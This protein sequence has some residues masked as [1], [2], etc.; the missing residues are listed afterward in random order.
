VPA[1]SASDAAPSPGTPARAEAHREI[2]RVSLELEGA[3]FLGPS[4]APVTLAM[5]L[6]YQCAF[7][8]RSHVTV[9]QLRERYGDRL[10]V[11]FLQNP[12]DNH[13]QAPLAARALLAA[14]A[15]GRLEEMHERLMV[16]SSLEPGAILEQARAAGLDPAAFAAGLDAA[17]HQARILEDRQ[18]AARIGATATPYFFVNGR[19]LR[20]AQPLESFTRLIDEEL[21]G[22]VGPTRWLA[23]VGSEADAIPASARQGSPMFDLEGSI[24]RG[25][26]DAPVTVVE[27]TD[28][29]CGFC[30]RSQAIL[31]RLLAEYKGKLQVVVKNLPL[32]FHGQA[33]AAAIASLA[34]DRQGKYWEYRRTLFANQ[35]ALSNENL[36]RFAREAGFD[37]KRYA[38]DI[39]S[40]ELA[41]IVDRDQEQAAAAGV[42][43]TPTFFVNGR[44]LVGAQ[45]FEAFKAIIDAE[46]ARAGAGT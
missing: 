21:S 39:A 19:P 37:M 46:L 12:L 17:G 25:R 33:R 42:E 38:K 45:P 5:F 1:P 3:P 23:S 36:E 8:K 32:D 26:E 11:V 44:I 28:Y 30:A 9:K 10:R 4:D 14:A 43:G 7:C 18:Q 15:L 35:Q 41:G 34:A 6:D 2:E 16:A 13:E 31:E 40:P 22:A 24:R 27:F 29:Q 20:G